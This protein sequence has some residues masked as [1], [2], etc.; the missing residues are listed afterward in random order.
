MN[1]KIKALKFAFSPGPENIHFG[2]GCDHYAFFA[3]SRELAARK[4]IKLDGVRW[5][6]RGGLMVPAGTRVWP[7]PLAKAR[8]SAL[9]SRPKT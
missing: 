2:Y 7:N 3:W 6:N 4:W 8:K 9:D 5:H 1:L